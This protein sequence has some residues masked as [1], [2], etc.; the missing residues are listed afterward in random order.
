MAPSAS[1][2]RQK[3]T[4]EFG[5]A[6]P[7]LENFI[8]HQKVNYRCPGVDIWVTNGWVLISNRVK[9][10]PGFMFELRGLMLLLVICCN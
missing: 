1:G 5:M 8:S 9:S 10:G 3:V 6:P 4:K 7:N 2:L